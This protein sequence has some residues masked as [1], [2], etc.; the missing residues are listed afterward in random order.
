MSMFLMFFV[1]LIFFLGFRVLSNV[2]EMSTDEYS[3]GEDSDSDA[4]R[5]GR[6]VAR[7]K[8]NKNNFFY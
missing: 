6:N 2:E 4:N 3:T 1:V 8:S 7:M 5:Q